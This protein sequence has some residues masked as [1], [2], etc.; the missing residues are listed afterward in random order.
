MAYLIVGFVCYVLGAYSALKTF[1]QNETVINSPD[2]KIKNSSGA[3]A[4]IDNPVFG[5]VTPK[6]TPEEK[7]KKKGFILFRPFKK[8]QK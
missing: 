3:S 2:I 4:T 8:K 5:K 6:E 7:P 1:P